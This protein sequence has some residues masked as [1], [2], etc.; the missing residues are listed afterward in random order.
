MK[1]SSIIMNYVREHCSIRGR[2]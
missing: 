1:A 2:I